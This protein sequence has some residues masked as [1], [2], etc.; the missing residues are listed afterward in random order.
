MNNTTQR[1]KIATILYSFLFIAL[2]VAICYAMFSNPLIRDRIAVNVTKNFSVGADE[3]TQ[4]TSQTPT[5]TPYIPDVDTAIY[6]SAGLAI[7][8]LIFVFFS[9]AIENIRNKFNLLE[10][11]RYLLDVIFS[12][13]A[14]RRRN[15]VGVVYDSFTR[16]PIKEAQI[17]LF[18]HNS[19]KLLYSTLSDAWGYYFITVNA[20]EYDLVVRKPGYSFPSEQAHDTFHYFE[21]LKGLYFAQIIKVKKSQAINYIIPLDP[22]NLTNKGLIRPPFLLKSSFLRL[23]VLFLANISNLLF[24]ALDQSVFGMVL[25][26]LYVWSFYL[27]YYSYN[28]NL[29]FSFIKNHKDKSPIDLAL[30]R[31]TDKEGKIL[32]TFTSDREG[33]VLPFAYNNGNKMILEQVGFEKLEL[34][35]LKQGFV[36]N[37]TIWLTKIKTEDDD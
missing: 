33:R 25:S 32:R 35:N 1:K 7:L 21:E 17:I 10:I 31:V 28:R 13:L 19:K 12:P 27:E 15:K 24:I 4:T 22:Q 20:G 5:N 2:T 30:I 3:L 37:K 26:A 16:Q 36:E 23:L 29:R 34:H 6:L 14:L 9:S 18:D 8:G 11:I